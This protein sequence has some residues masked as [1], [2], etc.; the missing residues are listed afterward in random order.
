MLLVYIARC[1]LEERPWS[2]DGEG[3]RGTVVTL[4]GEN[5]TGPEALLERGREKALLERH[6]EALVGGHGG[7]LVVE[8]PGGIGKSTL[9]SF[10][11]ERCA[12]LGIPMLQA[13]GGEIERDVPYGVVRQLF[14]RRVAGAGPWEQ[15]RLLAGAAAL[16]APVVDPTRTLEPERESASRSFP[17]L[18]GLYWLCANLVAISPLALLVDDLHWADEPSLR[19]LNYLAARLAGL[20]L[21]LVLAWRPQEPGGDLSLLGPLLQDPR[22][23]AL[24]PAPL[25]PKAAAELIASGLG[26]APQPEFA[27]ATHRATGGN[28]FLLSELVRT[29]ADERVSPTAEGISQ[30]DLATPAA[31]SHA[32]L[33]RLARLG[34]AAT[35]LAQAVAVLGGRSTVRQAAALADLG[36]NDAGRCADLLTQA[37]ILS[38]ANPLEFAHPILRSA[39]YAELSLTQRAIKH[40]RAA[41]LIAEGGAEPDAIAAH[42]LLAEPTADLWAIE[43]LR[44]AAQK[45]TAQGAPRLAAAC[46]KRALEEGPARRLGAELLMELG[47]AEAA[48][49]SPAA[50]EH[51]KMALALAEEPRV[52]ANAALVLARNLVYASRMSEAIET[53]D[54]ARESLGSGEERQLAVRL[55]SE[56]LEAAV[57][58]PEARAVVGERL[59]QF[60]RRATGD[61]WSE[62][63]LSAHLAMEAV[64]TGAAGVRQTVGYAERALAGDALLSEFTSEAPIFYLAAYALVLAGAAERADA[65]L[66]AALEDAGR[67]GSAI[68]TAIAANFRSLNH[69]R[70]GRLLEASADARQALD[71]ARQAGFLW[72]VPRAVAFLTDVC[73]ERNELSTADELLRESSLD[74]ELPLSGQVTPLLLARGRLRLAQRRHDEGLSD[75]ALCRQRCEHWGD[76]NPTMI[77]WRSVTAVALA[78]RE[79]EAALA[80]ARRELELAETFGE[81]RALGVALRAAG[82]VQPGERGRELLARAVAVLKPSQARL[83]YAHAEHDLGR[84]LRTA[85]R[86]DEAQEHLRRAMDTAAQCGATALVAQTRDELRA[87]GA[88]PRRER[89]S[90]IESLTASELRIARMAACGMSNR[91]I[92]ESLFVTLRTVETHL[93]HTYQKLDVSSRERLG[94]LVPAE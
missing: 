86:R 51:L 61:E 69:Y 18:H 48:T 50:I 43:Q 72:G 42:L 40:G 2:E 28:P 84:A 32:V 1:R 8:G 77:P 15:E 60:E 13:R 56:A 58:D 36:E 30:L 41:R 37:G 5:R 20:A 17:V 87:A 73:I 27:A 90:G 46:L 9:L 93:T 59:R 3:H 33:L 23:V 55:E 70:S 75:L 34:P 12:R 66:T 92:A 57:L 47:A 31:V 54:S 83:E 45:A 49:E 19:F 78:R 35:A 11:A 6:V 63:L 85:A 74:G 21:L 91:Q 22:R 81:P 26:E 89:L 62:R 76:E 94:Q 88:R 24:Q 25:T 82:T 65:V 16:A 68:G 71:V 44:A 80:L 64:R 52:R 7:W 14:E 4:W 10:A 29:L 38:G 53:L 39:V 67:R 79:P